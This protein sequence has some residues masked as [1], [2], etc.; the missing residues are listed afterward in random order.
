M[1]TGE[2]FSDIAMNEMKE[3][4]GEEVDEAK[5]NDAEAREEIKGTT[6]KTEQERIIDELQKKQRQSF[7]NMMDTF[8]SDKIFGGG[9]ISKKI[10]KLRELYKLDIKTVLNPPDLNTINVNDKKTIKPIYEKLTGRLKEAKLEKNG[11]D[12]MYIYA[13]FFPEGS[14]VIDPKTRTWGEFVK[15]WREGSVDNSSFGELIDAQVKYLDTLPE[16]KGIS[17]MH[18]R[19]KEMNKQMAQATMDTVSNGLRKNIN[20]VADDLQQTLKEGGEEALKQKC[21][22]QA[23]TITEKE[24]KGA[25]GLDYFYKFL[26]LLGILGLGW[27][28]FGVVGLICGCHQQQ[29]NSGCTVVDPTSEKQYSVKL[30][31]KAADMCQFTCAGSNSKIKDCVDCCG[32]C[33]FGGINIGAADSETIKNKCC[34]NDLDVDGKNRKDWNYQYDC[35][36]TVEGLGYEIKHGAENLADVLGD[37]FKK[38]GPYLPYIIG[39]IIAIILVPM[40]INMFKN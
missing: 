20:G 40:M 14:S 26:Y 10:V 3:K 35:I 18:N 34:N 22:E 4:A 39:I 8:L 33:G 36:S 19:V 5:A 15:R 9:K 6:D 24:G 29:L 38:I 30:T 7:F 17:D 2:N 16:Y 37:F 31:T 28:G 1:A 21:R 23:T 12:P 13:S 27:I 25:S 32:G 11:D